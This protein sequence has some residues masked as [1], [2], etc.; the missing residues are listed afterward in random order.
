L[1][2]VSKHGIVIQ[3]PITTSGRI[4]MPKKYLVAIAVAGVLTLCCAGA[5]LVGV[6]IPGT[7]ETPTPRPT[8]VPAPTFTP[9]PTDTPTPLPTDTPAPTYTPVPVPTDTPVP[10][11]TDT[12]PAVSSEVQQYLL[13]LTGHIIDISNALQAIGEL[14]STPDFFSNEWKIK[15]AAQVVVIRSAHEALTEMDVPPEMAEIHKAVLDA[16]SDCESSTYFLTTGIDNLD[17]AS[18]ETA[19]GLIQSCGEKMEIPMGMIG[20]YSE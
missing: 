12:P 4:A 7:S 11:P 13:E 10:V 20:E 18:L 14:A 1:I 5:M 15:M 17:A 3:N 2:P 16:T 6:L 8:D 9:P 19:S